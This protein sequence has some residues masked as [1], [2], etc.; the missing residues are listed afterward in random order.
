[1]HPI[2]VAGGNVNAAKIVLAAPDGYAEFQVAEGVVRGGRTFGKADIALEIRVLQS[3]Q[4]RND[5]IETIV[6]LELIPKIGGDFHRTRTG[7]RVGVAGGIPGQRLK[8]A[9]EPVAPDISDL[10]ARITMPAGSRGVELVNHINGLGQCRRAE[11]D[12][13]QQGEQANDQ[14]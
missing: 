9:A 1:M 6:N 2:G 12:G 5:A 13:R 11:A 3:I 4:R 10:A 7:I 14:G 8:R